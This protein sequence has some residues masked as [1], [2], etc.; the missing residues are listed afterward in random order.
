MAI[1]NSNPRIRKIANLAEGRRGW[2]KFPNSTKITEQV[3]I[4][5]FAEIQPKAVRNYNPIIRQIANTVEGETKLQQLR[6]FFFGAAISR[7]TN[8]KKERERGKRV[9]SGEIERRKQVTKQKPKYKG[10]RRISIPLCH[11][12]KKEY[13]YIYFF[14]FFKQTNKKKP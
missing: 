2:T 1:R 9:E 14:L 12:L 5:L 6:V 10:S 11:Q 13:I 3:R 7:E 4:R 8:G